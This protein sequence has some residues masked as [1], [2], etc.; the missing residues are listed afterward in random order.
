MG[1]GY[2]ESRGSDQRKWKYFRLM[3]EKSLSGTL[4][5]KIYIVKIFY[6]FF[7]ESFNALSKGLLE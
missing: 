5:V 3:G 2:G 4:S 6:L 1:D 7:Y